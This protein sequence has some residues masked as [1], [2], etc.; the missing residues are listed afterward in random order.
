M[1]PTECRQG[2]EVIADKPCGLMDLVELSRVGKG[3]INREVDW[4][5]ENCPPNQCWKSTKTK[6]ISAGW[7]VWILQKDVLLSSVAANRTQKPLPWWKNV[8]KP[9]GPSSVLS[10]SSLQF[11]LGKTRLHMEGRVIFD[12]VFCLCP[13]LTSPV[14]VLTATAPLLPCPANLLPLHGF[15]TLP[16]S[17]DS[18][19]VTFL[20]A[21]HARTS[22]PFSFLA[23][24]K[25]QEVTKSSHLQLLPP[26]SGVG[27]TD[28]GTVSSGYSSQEGGGKWA[29]AANTTLG[30][31]SPSHSHSRIRKGTAP[32][33]K[34]WLLTG[35]SNL[36]SVSCVE[37]APP[38]LVGVDK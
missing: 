29:Q 19:K 4:I 9:C 6:T 38:L 1:F 11:H 10:H 22:C 13:F 27:N 25:L 16:A 5:S 32:K 33:L 21:H 28:H 14:M 37:E 3:R 20:S 7:S 15:F 24:P 12:D 34:A 30:D 31:V 8:R 17:S 26:S 18:G 36:G 35:K 23:L 2:R